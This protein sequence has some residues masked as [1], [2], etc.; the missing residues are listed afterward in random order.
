MRTSR[1]GFLSAQ[2]GA[3]LIELIMFIVI[4]SLGVVGILSVLN[5]TAQKSADPQIRKQMVAAAE[6]LLEE[7]E[8]KPFTICDP[9]D[10]NAATAT[11]PADCTGGAGGANDESR[12]PL[13]AETGETRATYD[14]VSDYNGLT[15][16]PVSD[17][18]GNTLPGYTAV[19]SVVQQQLEASIPLAASLR[20]SVTVTRTG[21]GSVTLVGYR[22]RYAPRALP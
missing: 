4:V 18:A 2:G 20:I 14:N 17:I 10:V 8:L 19:V 21:G 16:N 12:L 6:A 5:L 9:D 22:L 7:V 13:G 11:V 15:L 1:P 3:T